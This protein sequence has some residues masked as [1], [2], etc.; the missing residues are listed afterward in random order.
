MVQIIV[1]KLKKSFFKKF[2]VGCVCDEK[3]TRLKLAEILNWPLS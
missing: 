2:I 3:K 1:F